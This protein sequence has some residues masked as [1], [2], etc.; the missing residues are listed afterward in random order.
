MN[1]H[2]AGVFD[3]LLDMRLP[4]SALKNIVSQVGK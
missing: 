1:N 2:S 3:A 4:D